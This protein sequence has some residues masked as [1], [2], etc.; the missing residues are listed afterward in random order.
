[1]GEAKRRKATALRLRALTAPVALR[2]IT[3]LAVPAGASLPPRDLALH[4]ITIAETV[5]TIVRERLLDASTACDIDRMRAAIDL[6]VIDGPKTTLP[7]AGAIVGHRDFRDNLIT[8]RWLEDIGL[9]AI[10]AG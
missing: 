1:M 6:F 10:M 3:K 4:A 5:R 2:P 9:P 7:L 8:T